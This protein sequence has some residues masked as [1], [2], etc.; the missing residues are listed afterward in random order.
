MGKLALNRRS[1]LALGAATAALS[2]ARTAGKAAEGVLPKLV[3][4]PDDII[5][6]AAGLRPFRSPPFCRK[7]EVA[8]AR[9]QDLLFRFSEQSGRFQVDDKSF[10]SAN[11]PRRTS[12]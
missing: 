10:M 7:E 3:V 2:G 1:L 6:Q 5:R 9:S 12:T 4:S 11:D 8:R